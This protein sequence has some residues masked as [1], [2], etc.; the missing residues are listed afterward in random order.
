MLG[1]ASGADVAADLQL[2][3]N[4]HCGVV[5]AKPRGYNPP[6]A[7]SKKSGRSNLGALK[8]EHRR[9]SGKYKRIAD[10]GPGPQ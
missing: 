10:G 5:V 7:P 9:T 3:P 8:A 6:R 1:M 4:E 2:V